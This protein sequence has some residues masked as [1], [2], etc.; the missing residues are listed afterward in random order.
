MKPNGK[1][2]FLLLFFKN[3]NHPLSL[4]S[5]ETRWQAKF[6]SDVQANVHIIICVRFS[7]AHHMITV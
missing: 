2:D 3:K 6:Y 7:F 4:T 1:N 5:R